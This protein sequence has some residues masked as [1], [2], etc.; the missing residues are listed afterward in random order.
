[1]I[2]WNTPSITG[3]N[4][5][6]L[7]EYKIMSSDNGLSLITAVNGDM[8]YYNITGLDYNTNY[9][10]EVTVINSCGLESIPTN[11]TVNKCRL[12]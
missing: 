3:G 9:G 4:G 12:W 5:I 11:V 10:A 6:S 1:M 8:L 7:S 2:R